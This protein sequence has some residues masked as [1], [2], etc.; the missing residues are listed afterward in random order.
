MIIR[1]G[2]LLLVTLGLG[3]CSSGG[4][5]SSG[6]GSLPVSDDPVFGGEGTVSTPDAESDAPS[7]GTAGAGAPTDAELQATD[8]VVTIEQAA[9]LVP[10]RWAHTRPGSQCL[11]TVSFSV[12]GIFEER[13]LD[14]VA[15]G[16]YDFTDDDGGTEINYAYTADN[17]RVDCF[18]DNEPLVEEGVTFGNHISFPDRDTMTLSLRPNGRG[19]ARDFTRQ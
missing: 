6:T 12:D 5:S 2:V 10:G 7:G 18:G 4:S 17:G 8:G 11:Q 15:G 9:A 3:A 1:S 14:K 19:F 13:E 16:F